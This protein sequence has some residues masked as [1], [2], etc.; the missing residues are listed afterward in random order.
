M[1]NRDAKLRRSAREARALACIRARGLASA[2]EIGTA[3]VRGEEQPGPRGWHAKERLGFALG[4]ALVRT[5][6]VRV[7]RHNQFEALSD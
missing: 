4:L 5:G 6:R 1:S 3:A 7:N 2:L